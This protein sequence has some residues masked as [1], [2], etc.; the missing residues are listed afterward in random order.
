[1]N[2][3]CNYYQ[4]RKEFLFH[5][6]MFCLD[7]KIYLSDF[8]TYSNKTTGKNYFNNV[9][10]PFKNWGYRHLRIRVLENL[11]NSSK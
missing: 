7:D 1:M 3:K 11:Q 8:F 6:E 5:D 9:Y 4:L 2:P 10:T